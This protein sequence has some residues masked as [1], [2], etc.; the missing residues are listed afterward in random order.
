[1]I[2]LDKGVEILDLR[3]HR[4]DGRLIFATRRGFG[5][6]AEEKEIAAQ[7]GADGRS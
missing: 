3:V 7:T 6:M 2:D 5:F 1:M 4:P